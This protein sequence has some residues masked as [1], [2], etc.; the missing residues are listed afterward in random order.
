MKHSEYEFIIL[1]V[2]KRRLNSFITDN[3]WRSYKF[4]ANWGNGTEIS[5]L[6]HLVASLLI[7]IHI[8]VVYLLQLMSLPWLTKTTQSPLYKF[9]V[10]SCC[11]I[12]IMI[13]IHHYVIIQNFFFGPHVLSV[14][15]IHPSTHPSIR[16]NHWSFYCPNSFAFPRLPNNTVKNLLRLASLT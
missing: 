9:I 6:C 15:P 8:R 7:N 14:L 3:F 11:C 12:W 13:F 4:T 10:H 5:H 1:A 2:S 16:G